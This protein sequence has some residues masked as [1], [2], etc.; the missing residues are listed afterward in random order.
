MRTLPP[1]PR[2]ARR[3]AAAAAAPALLTACLACAGTPARAA[4]RP[5]RTFPNPACLVSTVPLYSSQMWTSAAG[6]SPEA[7]VGIANWGSNTQNGG[8][9][10]PGK[11]RSA[12]DAAQISTARADGTRILG[13]IATDYARGAAGYGE[14]SIETQ[15]TDWHRWYGVTTFFLDEAPTAATHQPYYASLKAW[16]RQHIG[17]AAR[18]WLNM[19]AYPAA[20]SWMRDANTIMDWE[21]GA[22]PA[23]PPAW[24]HDYPASRFAMIMNAV[25]DTA[26]AISAA[27]T[28]IE[29]AH[30]GAGF[31]TSDASY[32]TLPSW[33]YWTTFSTDAASPACTQ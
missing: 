27:V 11:S 2:G 22:A 3:W 12:A 24:V 15:M 20:R 25:P 4:T 18:E 8:A 33:A 5:A 31:V 17:A 1:V 10:G 7:D 23:T 19:G 14:A 26:S 13:Y 28:D 9:G 29:N 32:Q 16:A 30:A 21:D 6:T